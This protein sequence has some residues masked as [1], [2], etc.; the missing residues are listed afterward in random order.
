MIDFFVSQLGVKAIGFLFLSEVVET[1]F[2]LTTQ[3]F[4]VV[5]MVASVFI[6]G[7]CSRSLFAV[8]AHRV[9]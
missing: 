9:E 6:V 2:F 4:S 5:E 3:T 7:R 1:T 8:V